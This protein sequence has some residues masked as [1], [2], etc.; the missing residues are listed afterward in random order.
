MA[1]VTNKEARTCVSRKEEFS[2]NNSTLYGSWCEGR[3]AVYSYGTHHIMWV[4]DPQVKL[5]FGNEAYPE[6]GVSRT[7]A[8]HHSITAPPTVQQWMDNASLASIRDNGW[9]AHLF[10]V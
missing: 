1:T 8:R 9:L 4:F 5:W 2:N 6:K 10:T 3:Y 7:T